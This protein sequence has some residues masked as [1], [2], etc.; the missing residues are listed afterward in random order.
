MT[1]LIKNF[2]IWLF[3]SLILMFL[4]QNFNFN[5]YNNEKVD[6]ST[7]MYELNQDQI[8]EVNINGREISVTRKDRNHYITY[9]PIYDSKLLNILLDKNVKIV[10]E[11]TQ[12]NSI[13]TT[14][15]ISWFPMI[16]LIIVWIFF[17]K[18]INSGNKNIFSF[19]KNKAKIFL[20]NEIKTTFNDIEGCD[21]AKE[22][23]REIVE[24]LKEPLFFKKL[25]GKI[26]KGILMIGPPGTGKTLLAR[27]VAGESKVPFFNISGSDFVEM[28]VGVG[29][30]RVRDMF[31]Q[32]KKISPCIIFIDEIDAV[33]RQRGSGLGGGHDERE[34][35][36][37]Q[38]LVEMD[39]F[40]KNENVIII[41]ATNRPDV[42]DK[43]LLRPG[44]FD[45]RIFVGLP[46]ISGR[47]K[48]LKIH[49]KNVPLDLDVNCNTI[50]RSTSGFSG[51]DLANL[52]NEAS[53]IAAKNKKS[54]VSMEDFEF[55]KD[56]LILGSER[57]S[58]IISDI[59]KE[60]TA[61]HESGHVIVG[62]IVPNYDPIHKVTIIPHGQALGITSFLP[63]EDLLS[64]DKE[65]LESKIS[66]LYGGRLAEEIIY[67][68][69]KISTGS[70]NDIK[71][72]TDIARNM[73]IKWGYSDIL[74]PLYIEDNDNNDILFNKNMKNKLISEETH[75]IIDK[76]IK[77][78][79]D[80]NYNRAKSILINNIDIL[81]KMKEALIKH[82]T[83]NSIQI[84][85]LMNRKK[86]I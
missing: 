49:M 17:I 18:Q 4:F 72:A 80:K 79:I 70:Q 1:D 2:I 26:P 61:Y 45:R 68:K 82:E 24:F 23:V 38:I 54:M 50:A 81:H 73:V 11:P 48:I 39:G 43:A 27:A 46:D 84:N 7:F 13:F 42:L 75:K 57:K 47:E 8:K 64:I 19:G 20:E 16:L 6:Y 67:G 65:K 83:L 30:S 35:T 31:D 53:L 59:Q 52:V 71:V 58:M 85:D 69:N 28:F 32:A 9:I 44:R 22:E 12:E 37:N 86:I 76:E 29:A 74:G 78:I 60:F 14:I 62:M 5:L 15:F 77:K 40:N 21:E 55:A 10:G 34:Q 41:A 51:A 56:K 66:T 3:I 25:G 63:K 33:G 36:L